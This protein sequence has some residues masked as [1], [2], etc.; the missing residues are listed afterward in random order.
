MEIKAKLV[1]SYNRWNGWTKLAL[2]KTEKSNIVENGS[3]GAEGNIDSSFDFVASETGLHWG[4]ALASNATYSRTLDGSNVLISKDRALEEYHI[5]DP[6][7]YKIC[8][9]R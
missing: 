9:N 8:Y 2:K 5:R 7:N 6:I 1:Y 4:N 3:L